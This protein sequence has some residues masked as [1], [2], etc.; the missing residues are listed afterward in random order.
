M[1]NSERMSSS[2]A[3]TSFPPLSGGA[4]RNGVDRSADGKIVE[5]AVAKTQ[6]NPGA[7]AAAAPSAAFESDAIAHLRTTRS[8]FFAKTRKTCF[9]GCWAEGWDSRKNHRGD[10]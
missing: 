10:P 8:C 6:T 4:V 3:V 7:D 9:P 1:V 5:S 2:G